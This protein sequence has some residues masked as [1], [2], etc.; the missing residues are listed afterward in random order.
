[1]PYEL[2]FTRQTEAEIAFFI[3]S[4]NKSILKK[5]NLLLLEIT[6][7]PFEGS[8]KPEA[9]KYELF[10]FWS[11]RINREHRLV[12]EVL[13]DRIVIHSLKGHYE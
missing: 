3:K 4:G 8:G 12:Y 5:I 11:R 9:L 7:N 6:E 13:H 10:G 2:D 1:M